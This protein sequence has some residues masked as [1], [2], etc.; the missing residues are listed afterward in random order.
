MI[1]YTKILESEYSDLVFTY[2]GENHD[3]NYNAI[4]CEGL[5]EQSVL[6]AIW[7][8]KVKRKQDTWIEFE[9]RRVN[10]LKDTDHFG[11]SDNTM[12]QGMAEYRQ[13]LRDLP[14]TQEPGYNEEGVFTMQWPIKP[15]V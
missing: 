13:A 1:N 11:L 6:D 12:P 14:L 10:L 4:V 7:D 15:T 2:E 3:Y 8:N 9:K 5:P